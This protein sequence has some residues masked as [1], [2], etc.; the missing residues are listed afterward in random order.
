MSR[1]YDSRR[2][3]LS[4][5]G[6]GSS[7]ND[8]LLDRLT[9]RGKGAYVFLGSDAASFVTAQIISVDGGIAAHVPTY[10]DKNRAGRGHAH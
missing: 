3:R 6:V 10:A 8:Y 5:V 7:F 4:G 2:I 9:E 1:F